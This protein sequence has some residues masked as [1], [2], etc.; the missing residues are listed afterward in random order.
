M[1]ATD[2]RFVQPSR[3]SHAFFTSLTPLFGAGASSPHATTTPNRPTTERRKFELM[4]PIGE[5][6]DG[7]RIDRSIDAPPS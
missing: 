5:R 7:G 3:I 4:V 6:K 1:H 2:V